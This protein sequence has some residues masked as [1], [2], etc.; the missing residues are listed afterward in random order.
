MIISPCDRGLQGR[1]SFIILKN[2][3]KYCDKCD[4]VIP[5][6]Y[7]EDW[8]ETHEDDEAI[9]CHNCIENDTLE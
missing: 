4:D 5:E 2:T 8:Y 1:L 3:M 9:Y 6:W 7:I